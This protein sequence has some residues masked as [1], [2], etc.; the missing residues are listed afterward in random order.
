[1]S[2]I[3]DGTTQWEPLS[4]VECSC[5]GDVGAYANEEDLFEDGQSLICGCHGW[6][7]VEE[8]GDIWVNASECDCHSYGDDDV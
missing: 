6:V 1:M 4:T 3:L 8:D 7:V 2:N 5:C